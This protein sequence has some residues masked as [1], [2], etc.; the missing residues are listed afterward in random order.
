MNRELES[1]RAQ[2]KEKSR[3][4]HR[5]TEAVKVYLLKIQTQVD[6]MSNVRMTSVSSSTTRRAKRPS[7]KSGTDCEKST[8]CSRESSSRKS[9]ASA[10]NGKS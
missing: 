2:I 1:I 4:F 7:K 5:I 8:M 10:K 9:N 3:G 6:Q